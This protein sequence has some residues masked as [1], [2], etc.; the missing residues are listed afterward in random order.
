ML[1]ELKRKVKTSKSTIGELW[2]GERFVCFTLEDV[3]RLAKIQGESAIPEGKYN[4]LITHSSKFDKE[5][6]LLEDVK[7]FSGI[8]IHSGNYAKDT[9]GCVLVGFTKGVDF[10]GQSRNAF[11]LVFGMIK[12]ALNKGEKVEIEILSEGV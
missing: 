1:M 11:D 2:I 12:S 10:I 9:E 8:R 4:V 3:V 5:L 7:G 6:P